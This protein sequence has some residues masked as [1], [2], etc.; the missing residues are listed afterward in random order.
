MRMRLEVTMSVYGLPLDHS[1]IVHDIIIW[2][3]FDRNIRLECEDLII[4]R[5]GLNS[6]KN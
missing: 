1:V 2:L 4:L 3:G 5:F 6:R